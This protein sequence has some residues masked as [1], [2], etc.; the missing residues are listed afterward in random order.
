LKHLLLVLPVMEFILK[1]RR[2]AIPEKES[3]VRSFEDGLSSET[4]F[5]RDWRESR[6]ELDVEINTG[7][8]SGRSRS[9]GE[10]ST[11]G[12]MFTGPRPDK[13]TTPKGSPSSSSSV[14]SRSSARGSGNSVRQS[15]QGSLNR[16]S[17]TT[18]SDAVDTDGAARH[19]PFKRK[20][21]AIVTSDDEIEIVDGPIPVTNTSKK[22]KA[23]AAAKPKTRHR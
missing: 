14:V 21:A 3:N 17:T 4:L 6:V 10:Q 7:A 13:R 5:K 23:K 9:E 15:P 8:V 19:S 16:H 11:S 22:S 12:A 18:T 20:A 2:S 1:Q